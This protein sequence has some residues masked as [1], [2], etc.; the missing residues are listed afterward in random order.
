MGREEGRVREKEREGGRVRKEG[1]DG[2]YV[3][4]CGCIISV[5]VV[6]H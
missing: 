5:Y 4:V 2:D 6:Q 3:M 1:R